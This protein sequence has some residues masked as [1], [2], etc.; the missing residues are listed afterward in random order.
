MTFT[1]VM[2]GME[3]SN[4]WLSKSYFRHFESNI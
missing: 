4:F 3:Y 1:K 2:L